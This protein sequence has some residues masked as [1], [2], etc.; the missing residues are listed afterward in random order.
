MSTTLDTTRLHHD[1]HTRT[2]NVWLRI[3]QVLLALFLLATIMILAI[4]VHIARGELSMVGRNLSAIAVSSFVAWGRM[5]RASIPA[6][7]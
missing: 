3:A 1:R 2:L 5:L 7:A 4:P 6:R